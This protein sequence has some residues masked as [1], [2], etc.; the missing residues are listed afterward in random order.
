[1]FV[2]KGL[3]LFVAG[4]LA[5]S[6]GAAGLEDL[7]Q[8]K[9]W[10]NPAPGVWKATL[11]NMKGELRYTDIAAEKPRLEALKEL[12][13]VPFPFKEGKVGVLVSSD[14]RVMIRIPASADERLFGFGL[15]MDSIK[16]SRQ[17]LEL[18]VDHWS[19]GGG[20]THA[21]VP[22][23]ISSKGYGV[24]FNTARFLKV[25]VQIGN[26]KDSKNNPPFVDRNP[27]PNEPQPGAWQAVPFADAVEAQVHGGGL[28]VV[29]FSGKSLLDVVSRYNLYCGGGALP[30]LWGMGFW[31]RVPAAF[32]ADQTRAEV[33][34]FEERDFPL[35]VI[36]LE[37]GWQTK[38]Y[39]CTFEW[40]T[41]RFP[42]P[43]AFT[44]E[45][46]DKGVHLNL[47]ENPY[48]SPASRIYQA[49]YPLSASHTVWLGI[50]PDYTIPKARKLLTDQHYEDHIRIGVSG[51]K[52]DEVDG[53]DQ[54]LWPDHAT[55][56]SGTSAEAMRQ[57]YGLLLQNMLYTDLFKQRNVRTYGLVRASNGAASGYPFVLYS[58]SYSHSQYITGVSAA[59]LGGILWCP[60]VRSAGSGREWLNR[61]QTVCFS[62]MAMLNAWSSGKKPWS[63]SDVTD[64]VR[65]VIKLRMQLLPY[66]YTAFAEYNRKG[67][68][69]VR[70]M[71]LE[72]GF[73]LNERV[74]AG[75]L[76]SEKNPYAEGKVVETTDQFMFGPSILVAPFYEK[77]GEQRTVELPEGGNWYDF[78]SG[79]LVGNG[80]KITVTAE[81]LQ[82]RTPLFVKEGAVIPMLTKAVN[83]TRQAYAHP[84]EVRVYGT[85][86]GSFELYEDDGQ[87][88]DYQQGKYRIRKL[89]AANGKVVEE[90]VKDGAP[91]MFGPVESVK[92]MTQ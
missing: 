56:P 19:R 13:S 40:Q 71:I 61:T 60:E 2:E 51:Y 33:K 79:K 17:V 50:V 27:P 65:D 52:I 28:E 67:T 82:E 14:N 48:I 29:V 63:Y 87:T 11:G 15:Q 83:T 89:T 84:L 80:G 12:E 31:H 24:F 46:L 47:W 34:E 59:S 35:D 8:V 72:S 88:F 57:S 76:D 22:F 62:H 77:Q 66:I 3:S 92:F 70:A 9:D 30:P 86:G 91:A 68:P 49:M 5:L 37:P 10:E 20:R 44:K 43:E 53:Y 7:S 36:G 42:D 21:P 41:K 32:T 23:Y 58:D 1:M 45:L 54:W 90:V 69:P 26:R 18:N 39:P 73:K 16:K 25:Y 78:Y 85:V 6:I 4:F 55:F 81:G 75:Q 64:K 38:S 74:I